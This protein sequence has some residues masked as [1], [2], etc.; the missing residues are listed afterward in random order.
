MRKREQVSRRTPRKPTPAPHIC[1]KCKKPIEEAYA[2]IGG[3]VYH[4]AC[5]EGGS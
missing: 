5:P 4:I 2:I 3:K 1:A